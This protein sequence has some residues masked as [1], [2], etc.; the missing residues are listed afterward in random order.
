MTLLA[1]FIKESINKLAPLYPDKEARSIVLLLCE[2]LLGTKSYTHIVDPSYEIPEGKLSPLSSGMERLTSGEPVQYVLGE[3]EFYGH[4]FRVTPD[5][6][7]PRPETEQLCRE[8]IGIGSRMFR[9]WQAYGKKAWPVRIL[10][11]CTGSGCI[12]W[13]MALSVPSSEVVAVDISEGALEVAKSQAFAAEL[14]A[15]GT[16][17]PEFVKADVLD[18]EQE[19]DHG[20]FNL[21]LSNPPY[22]MDKEKPGLR[23]NLSFEPDSALFV[24]DDDPLVFYKAIARWSQRFLRPEGSGL[25]EINELLGAE[26]AACFREA[27]FA[28]E[29]IKDFSNKDRFVLYTRR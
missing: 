19:F 6:L 2:R 26:T 11:L 28:T 13:T 24:R 5:V 9:M 16:M 10:D 20:L 29:I 23:T 21:I 1:D 22:I 3:A 7:I 25:T 17:L 12:A 18:T 27:G 4:M 8:A 14:K 15:A